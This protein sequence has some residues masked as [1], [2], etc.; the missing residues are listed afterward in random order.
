MLQSELLFNEEIIFY[1]SLP[2]NLSIEARQIT[3]WVCREMLWQSR[4]GDEDYAGRRKLI[5][6]VRGETADPL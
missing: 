1:F 2:P 3:Y 4:C 6:L 5:L